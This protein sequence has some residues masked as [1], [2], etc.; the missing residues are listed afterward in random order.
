MDGRCDPHV[1][2]LILFYDEA[3]DS[4]RFSFFV[5]LNRPKHI[6]LLLTARNYHDFRCGQDARAP[7]RL[8]DS[9]R[10]FA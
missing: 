2:A 6:W 9:Q 3:Q 5:R 7:K 4:L 8:F 10:R 1:A